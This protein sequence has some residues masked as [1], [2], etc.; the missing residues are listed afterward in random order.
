MHQYHMCFGMVHFTPNY[1]QVQGTSEFQQCQQPG[2]HV[3]LLS[4]LPLQL[5]HEDR[6]LNVNTFGHLS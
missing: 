5:R 3:L 6:L 1:L 2:D 4:G